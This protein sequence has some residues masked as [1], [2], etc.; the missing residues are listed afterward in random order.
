MHSKKFAKMMA[1]NITRIKKTHPNEKSMALST[2]NKISY[3]NSKRITVSHA[4]CVCVCL[5]ADF[6]RKDFYKTL[7]EVPSNDPFSCTWNSV[8]NSNK[9]YIWITFYGHC[10]SSSLS[11]YSLLFSNSQFSHLLSVQ[12]VWSIEMCVYRCRL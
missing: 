8:Q 9:S 5:C 6:F 3:T 10:E 1:K 4:V 12:R 7:N 11:S 2:R